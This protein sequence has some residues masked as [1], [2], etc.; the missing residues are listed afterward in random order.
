M[1]QYERVLA[2]L[3]RSAVPLALHE[4]KDAILARFEQMDSEA[5]ISARIR[6][7]RHDLEGRKAGTVE[8]V[9]APGR[10]WYRYF[11]ARRPAAGNG[12]E[13]FSLKA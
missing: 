2:V 7:I 13:G 1:T 6:D 10:A 4:I 3:D 11:V 8:A 9:R 5:G 12:Q